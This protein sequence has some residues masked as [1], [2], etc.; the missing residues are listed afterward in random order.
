MKKF[1]GL[2]VLSLLVAS[3][4]WAQGTAQIGGV[5]KDAS[6]AVIPGAEIKATQTATGAVRTTTSGADGGFVMPNL[7]IGPY[8]LEATKQGFSKYV[9]SGLQ[10]NV[11][12]NPTL[13]ISLKVGAS[14]DQVTVEA[15]ADAIETHSNNVGEVVDNK[16]VAEMPLNGRDPHELIFLAGMSQNP[17]GGAINTVRNYPTVVVSVA[18][19]QGNGVGYQLDGTIFQDPYNNLSLPLPFPDALQEFK[20]ETS[21][22]PAQYGYHSTATVNAVTKSGTNEYHGDLFEFLRNGD[23]NARDYFSATRDSIKRNQWGG[24]IGGRIIKDKLFF[25]GGYQRT[26][27]RSDPADQTSYVPTAAMLQGNFTN[28]AK[29]VSAGGCQTKQFNLSNGPNA[30]AAP[31]TN[32]VI[33]QSLISPVAAKFAATLPVSNDPCGLIQYGFVNK[34]DEDLPVAKIDWQKSEKH[35][36]FGRFT[37]GNLNQASTYDGVNPLTVNSYGVHDLDYQLALGDTYLVGASIVNSFR[38]SASRTNIVKVPSNY[39]NWADFGSNYTPSPTGGESMNTT[40]SGGLGF[41]VGSSSSTPG[42]SHNGPN[43]SV[44]DDITW[45]KGNHQIGFGGNIYRQQMNYWSGVNAIGS[46]TFTGQ[47]TGGGNAANGLGMADLLLGQEAGFSQG[48]TYGFYSRQYYASLYVQD[49]WKVTSRLTINYGVRWEPYLSIFLKHDQVENVSAS[50][51]AAGYKGSVFTNAPAG[52]VVGGDPHYPCGSSIDCNDWHKFLPRLGL[53]YDP[54]GDGKTVIRAAF[55]EFEDRGHMFMPN[56][57]SFSPP[58]GDTVAAPAANIVNPWSNYPGG[59]PLP[60]LYQ[61]VGVGAASKNAPFPYAG[62]FVNFPLDGYNPMYVEQWNLGIQHQFSNWMVTANYLGNHTVHMISSQAA[63]PA[64]FLGTGACTL[65]TLSA[66]GTIVQTPYSTCST[67]ANQNFRRV[68]FLQNPAQGAY[69]AGIG[70]Q[71]DSGTAS[72]EG[73]FVSASRSL[74]KGL[75]LNTNFTWSHCISDQY[76]QQTT[77]TGVGVS[78]PGNLAA[79]RGSCSPQDVR[80]SWIFNGVYTTPKMANRFATLLLGGWQIAPIIQIRSGQA[81]NVL[82]GLDQALTT[83]AGQTPVQVAQDPYCAVKNYNCWL[84]PAA[85]AQPALGTYS[86]MRGYGAVSG[87]PLFQVNVAL[88]RTFKIREK[89]SVQIRAEAFNLPNTLNPNNPASTAINSSLFG[90]INTDVAG[91]AAFSNSGDYRIVQ[92]AAKFVF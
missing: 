83:V 60:G 49:S 26:S 59:N 31:F 76:D 28:D 40:V 44:A 54:K 90:K 2:A 5:V 81:L 27:L 82:S 9:Q 77:Q 73:A 3:L 22:L 4:G 52:L 74:S 36:I 14:N 17:G 91:S 84:S 1:V 45:I 80:L 63:N 57:G 43:P 30:G 33:P 47:Y 50:L 8:Q 15:A 34:Y 12:S 29:P 92:L 18:G 55:G 53:A 75:T 78:I 69:Y 62:G 58:F 85:F 13:D 65:S 68:L 38:L 51:F 7:P 87:P 39:K 70:Q 24:V 72:Y 64:V 23:L 89:Q 21:A 46:V 86:P 88:S 67:T 25:F 66:A 20:L 79:Y 71:L 35:T 48:T 32:N 42:Q 10:L 11:D 41:L 6:G 37:E 61:V 19:G 56:Q 16:R